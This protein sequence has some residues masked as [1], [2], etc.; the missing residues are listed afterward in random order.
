M[1]RR[2]PAIFLLPFVI[3]GI[4]VADYARPSSEW[5][6]M[7]T[8]CACLSGLVLL[9]VKQR[10]AV[11]CL[12]FCLAGAAGLN[13]AASHYDL[14]PNG[15]NEQ[16]DPDRKATIFARVTAWP[17]VKSNGTSFELGVDSIGY[18]GKHARTRG[19]ILLRVSDLTT[20]LQRG[21][22]IVLEGR[23][24]PLQGGYDLSGF[25]YARYLSRRGIAGTV[26][27]N[28]L[29]RVRI[30]T[31]QRSWTYA[32]VAKI[33]NRIITSFERHLGPEAAALASGFL[34]G[35]TRDIPPSIYTR[36]R[37]SGTLH[38]LA[39]SG[40]N[41]A[42]VVAFVVLLLR[43][44]RIPRRVRHG[45]L[46]LSLILFT[47]LSYSEPS[48]VRAA[49]MAS[50]VL[51]A[52][53]LERRYD[54]N[55]IIAL[56]ALIILMFDPA[57]LFGVGF[58]LSF[59]TAWGLIFVVP[60]LN[61]SP[62]PDQPNPWRRW[63]L[64]AVAV[65]VV[66]QLCSLP[67]VAY[68]FQR[69]PWLSPVANLLIVPAVSAAVMVSL[70]LLIVDLFSTTVASLLGYILDLWSDMILYLL[71]LFGGDSS[72]TVQTGPIS[73]IA[74]FG[75]YTLLVV[76]ILA[77][78]RRRWRRIL[79]LAGAPAICGALLIAV[80]SPWF[81]GDKYEAY[82]FSVPGGVAA[83]VRECGN[84][85]ADL[86]VTGLESR[87][88]RLDESILNKQLDGQRIRRLGRVILLSGD[89][90]AFDDLLRTASEYSA[91]EVRVP[92][93]LWPSISDVV[94]HASPEFDHLAMRAF[95]P[96]ISG[97]ESGEPG[98]YPTVDGLELRFPGAVVCFSQDQSDLSQRESSTSRWQCHVVGY[99]ID[100]QNQQR[101]SWSDLVICTGFEQ[102]PAD[103]SA[104]TGRQSRLIDLRSEGAIRV[105]FPSDSTRN[106][107][108][109]PPR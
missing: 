43:P 75:Y 24:V 79:V 102:I 72:L 92:R 45:V 54:L 28:N 95:D 47:W 103:T 85:R 66:A 76:T 48:V 12:A 90:A 40:S 60:R 44:L 104:T 31:T 71:D 34:I 87:R 41:V 8:L 3:A 50:L 4:V 26:Y 18:D 67:L 39:V 19:R 21:D 5:L 55:N 59:V 77:W 53:F 64:F 82:F 46:W 65:S 69:V 96:V 33:R 14:G 42:L 7:S 63:L 94:T 68:Y 107:T 80:A 35:E 1:L 62:G 52:Q 15:I 27:K 61:L 99:R 88:Y 10:M 38:L 17:V 16:I 23:V 109:G 2:Y 29:L 11:V 25:S 49:T 84:S 6:L 36:F 51:A 78:G 101:L 13:Y 22:R 30:D 37:D 56:T 98:Y 86:I 97:Q 32:G 58:Q 74:V 83:V 108:F 57:Q 91:R 73:L 20:Q 100:D 89:Y 93:K 106:P 105:G 81:R 70:A 9:A